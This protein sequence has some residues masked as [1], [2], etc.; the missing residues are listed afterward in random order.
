LAK[1]DRDDD[2][3]TCISSDEQEHEEGEEDL[4]A[5]VDLELQMKDVDGVLPALDIVLE[6]A[7]RRSAPMLAVY[8]IQAFLD[9]PIIA[10][11]SNSRPKSTVVNFT[12]GDAVLVILA[13]TTVHETGFAFGWII[14]KVTMNILLKELASKI[15]ASVVILIQPFW[16]VVW[17]IIFDQIVL[18]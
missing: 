12:R 17:A 16:P 13:L 11:S 1:V 6:N 5:L 9:G 4:V 2:K 8:R 14:G 7:R 10:P 18:L 15:P 3:I